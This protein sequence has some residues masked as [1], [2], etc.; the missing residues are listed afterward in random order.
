MGCKF[1]I[2]DSQK[3]YKHNDNNDVCLFVYHIIRHDEST[4]TLASSIECKVY[5]RVIM[6]VESFFSIGYGN[7]SVK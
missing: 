1:G 3:L 5:Y 7:P 6:N 2:I 4:K